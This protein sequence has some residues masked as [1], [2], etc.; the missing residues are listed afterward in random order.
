[1][2]DLGRFGHHHDPA[3]DFCIEVECIEGEAFNERRGIPIEGPHIDDRIFRAMQFR[4][5]GDAGAIKAKELLREI[6]KARRPSPAV[7]GGWRDIASAPKDGT[8]FLTFDDYYGVRMGRAF[9]RADHDDWLSYVDCNGNSSKGGIR[10][11]HWQPLPAPP[12]G[13]KP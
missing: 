12:A 13:E 9:I 10:A 4:T 11:T 6:E 8:R 3:I 7:E 1:M 2:A 5:G